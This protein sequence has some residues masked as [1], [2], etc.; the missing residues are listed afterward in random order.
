MKT[1]TTCTLHISPNGSSNILAKLRTHAAEPSLWVRL[2]HDTP[3]NTTAAAAAASTCN[4]WRLSRHDQLAHPDHQRLQSSM[5]CLSWPATACC[6]LRRGRQ[7]RRQ[8]Q[9][10]RDFFHWDPLAGGKLSKAFRPWHASDLRDAAARC[11]YSTKSL[12]TCCS[13]DKDTPTSF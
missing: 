5:Q 4:P 2:A 11:R 6:L 9:F 1:K 12:A 8:H 13:H 7:C 3:G 10:P